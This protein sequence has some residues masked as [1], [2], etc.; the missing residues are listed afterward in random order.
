MANGLETATVEP[1]NFQAFLAKDV[2]D[3]KA[4]IESIRQR[5]K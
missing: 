1:A 4:R 2:R 3:W 5:I